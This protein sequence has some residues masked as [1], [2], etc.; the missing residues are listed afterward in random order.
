MIAEGLKEGD[1][2]VVGIVHGLKEGLKVELTQV[3]NPI[4]K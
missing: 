1:S 3:S 2:V 4:I